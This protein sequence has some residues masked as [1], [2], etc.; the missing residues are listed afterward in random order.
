MFN[1]DRDAVRMLH[2]LSDAIRVVNK[3]PNCRVSSVHIAFRYMIKRTDED[4]E[5]CKDV[6]SKIPLFRFLKSKAKPDSVVMFKVGDVQMRYKGGYCNLLQL[7][8]DGHWYTIY[9]ED[10]TNSA[11][12]VKILSK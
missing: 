9:E 1:E 12:S 3:I 5:Q 8:V 6:Y 10:L 4:W 11:F 7:E 2:K